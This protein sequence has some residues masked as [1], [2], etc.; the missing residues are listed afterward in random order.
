MEQGVEPPPID[1]YQVGEVYFVRDGQ[2]R[3][4][5]ARHLGWETIRANVVEVTTRAPVGSEINAEELLKAAE[6]SKFLEQTQLDVNRPGARLE[7]SQLGRYDKIFEHILGHRYFLGLDRGYE[8]SIPEAAMSWYDSVYTPVMN[9]AR[10]HQLMERLPRWTETD[11]YL[12]LTRIWLDLQEEGLPAGPESAASLLVEQTNTA[13]GVR[14]SLRPSRWL[15][16]RR[17][18]E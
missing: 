4:S 11:I 7:C 3:V 15:A 5:V 8:V 6:Y 2:T 13:E 12:A 16:P 17:D 10:S 18:R 14:K 9:V 1:V